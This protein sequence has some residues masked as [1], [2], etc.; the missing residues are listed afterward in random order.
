MVQ[1]QLD[2]AKKA[3][4]RLRS[5]RHVGLRLVFRIPGTRHVP[6]SVGDP[7]LPLH[8]PEVSAMLG[9]A[10]P[11]LNQEELSVEPMIQDLYGSVSSRRAR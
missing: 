8:G 2:I 10:S 6:R 3:P 7:T 11:E 5:L 1:G 9:V 4:L